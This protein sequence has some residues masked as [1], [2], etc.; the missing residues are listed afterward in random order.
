[1]GRCRANRA[2]SV[3]AG[4]FGING[5]KKRVRR[6]VSTG[7]EWYECQEGAK[8]LH[9]AAFSFQVYRCARAADLADWEHAERKRVAGGEG[10]G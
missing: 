7:A 9:G 5:Q 4:E 6:W 1:M 8:L 10:T 3:A 2:E